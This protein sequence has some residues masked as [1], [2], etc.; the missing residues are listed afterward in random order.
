MHW[1][2]SQFVILS[3]PCEFARQGEMIDRWCESLYRAGL[4]IDWVCDQS[5]NIN[6]FLC[7][8]DL[9]Q[10]LEW[11]AVLGQL[12]ELHSDQSRPAVGATRSSIRAEPIYAESVK[13]Q[14]H[15]EKLS[16]P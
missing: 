1:I 13:S 4:D 2:D 11:P 12:V 9:Q 8:D 3:H 14:P 6:W 15:A 5:R 7:V 16:Y 10:R